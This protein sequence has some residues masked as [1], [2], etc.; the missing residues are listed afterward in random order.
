MSAASE[1]MGKSLR[2]LY[3]ACAHNVA[4]DVNQAV[5]ARITE[6][7]AERDKAIHIDSI[8]AELDSLRLERIECREALE[9]LSD[10]HIQAEQ[11][12]EALREALTWCSEQVWEGRDI[13]GADF[14]D[15]MPR[16]TLLVEVP[17]S[18]E[19]EA[20]F[21]TSTMFAWKWSERATREVSDE[22]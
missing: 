14:Q 20:E 12:I 11:E 4:K 5:E 22:L 18:E 21:D 13:D 17:A 9:T 15:E 10:K 19:V 3:I 7:E 2:S 16:R 8:T 1:Y 6:L